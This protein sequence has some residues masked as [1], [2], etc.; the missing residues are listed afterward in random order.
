MPALLVSAQR[1]DVSVLDARTEERA[2]AG[3][4]GGGDADGLATYRDVEVDSESDD[5]EAQ[6]H[7][8]LS[9]V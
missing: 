7:R 1:L 6:D 2:K 8:T 9:V 3:G 4:G 5:E